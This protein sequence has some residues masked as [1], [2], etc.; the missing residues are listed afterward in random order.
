MKSN[1]IWQWLVRDWHWPAAAAVAAL[2]LLAIL[3]LFAWQTSLGLVLVFVQLPAY[4]LHQW[5]EHQG[6]RFRLYFNRT[7]G[8]G[9]E[10]LTPA[11]TFWI[12][13]IG[14]WCVDLAALYLA[15]GWQPAAGLLAAYMSLFNAIVHF[16]A[17][18]A[19]R[20][21]NPGLFTAAVLFVPLGG[22]CVFE[23]GKHTT[24]IE[25]F[26]AL[27]SAVGIHVLIIVYVALRLRKLR[28]A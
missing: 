28:R 6:D 14:V 3:P 17:A 19:R 18:L 10:A 20:E 21:Y 2:F 25:Q 5:E 23:L 15:W 12:N 1:S 11:A 13:S 8:A 27:A 4:L 24:L 16:G 7:I 22:W 26:V 9:R